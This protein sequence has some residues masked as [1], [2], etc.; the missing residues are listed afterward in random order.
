MRKYVPKHEIDGRERFKTAS[1]SIVLSQISIQEQ[2]SQRDYMTR[3]ATPPHATKP[4]KEKTS[5]VKPRRKKPEAKKK[6]GWEMSAK[7]ALLINF[8]V[9]EI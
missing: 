4:N 3:V 1:Q 7:E 2:T 9:S 5:V 8:V 6:D